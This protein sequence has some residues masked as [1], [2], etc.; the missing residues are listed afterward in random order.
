MRTLIRFSIANPVGVN[1]IFLAILVVGGLCL[2]GLPREVFPDFARQGV[3]VQV[4]YPN[5]SPEEVERL[6]TIPIEEAADAV[7]G[8]WEILSY[9]RQDWARILIRLAE[10]TD[11]QQYLDELRMEIDAIEDWP[12]DAEEPRVFEQRVEFPV[13]TVNLFGTLDERRTRT[14]VERLRDRLK[15]LPHVAS[16]QVFGLRDPEIWIEADQAALERY[17]VSLPDLAAALG[18]QVRDLP[19]GT[20][21][22]AAG[23]L[24]L[25]VLGEETDPE[26]LA[27]RPVRALPDGRVVRVGDLARVSLGF[28]RARTHSRYDGYESVSLNVTKDDRGDVIEMVDR[29]EEELDDFRPTL[30]PGLSVGVSSDFSIYVENRL[31]TLLQSGLF[32]LAIVLV[33]LWLFLDA[34]AA[35]M[36]ALGIPVAVTG[37][38]I[39]MSLLGITMNMLSMFAFILVLGMV[40]DD[41]IVLVENCFRHLEEGLPPKAAAL[42]GAQEVAWPVLTTV[43]TTVAAFGAMLM[44]EGELGQWM[45]PVPWVASVTLFAS[46]TEALVVLPSHF[47]EWM[48]AAAPAPAAAAAAARRPWYAGLQRIYERLLAACVGHRYTVLLAA[49]GALAC[50]G[51]LY[52]SGHLKFVLLPRFEAKLFMVNLEAPSTWSLAQTDELVAEVDR[53]VAGLPPEELESWVSLTGVTYA[54]QTNYRNGLHLGQVLVELAEGG[55]RRRST[56]EIQEDLRGRIGRPP[57]LVSLEFAEPN[58]GPAGEPIELRLTAEDDEVRRAAAAAVFAYLAGFPGVVDLKTDLLPGPRELRLRLTDEGR[59]LGF[60]ESRLAAQVLGAFHGDRAAILRLGR[61]P[62]DLLVRNPEAARLDFRHLRELR[63][64]APS[65]ASL[66]LARVAEI[67][68]VRGLAEIVR[69]DRRRAVTITA[70]VREDANAREIVAQVEREFADLDR[71]FPG[72]R[73]SSGGDQA[74]TVESIGSLIRALGVAAVVIYFLLAFLFRSYLQPGVVL[75]AVPFGALGVAFGFWALGE[76]ISFM[77]MLGLMALS[78]VAV[79]DSLVLVDFI[80]QQRAAGVGVAAAVRRAGSVR[81]RPVLITSLTTIGGLTPLAFF[82]SGQARFLSPMAQALIFGMISSTLMTLLLVPAGYLVLEDLKAAAARLLGRRP[83]A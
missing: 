10:D 27:R 47:A 71:R 60:D 83:A 39:M 12:E 19:G 62:A 80:N 16:V 72:A 82:A 28:A 63:V 55:G 51:A 30:P 3:E 43:T 57:G 44:I 52:A 18:G 54:D 41:A 20:L 22:T 1:L 35:L 53:A 50:A 59:M 67:E 64:R 69:R 37:G 65:G 8:T 81:M 14:V 7:Q 9:S 38:V 48:P 13:I 6:C 23:E 34:R 74:E 4:R 70:D 73:M 40:V 11:L 5:A 56:A 75:L 32:G 46:L 25:R 42:R 68:E 15:R 49:F 2:P 36:T 26:R 77:T 76:P 61:D 79:N 29:I 21:E 17:Q 33:V 45:E 78:G 66:P 31:N 58:A 24:R